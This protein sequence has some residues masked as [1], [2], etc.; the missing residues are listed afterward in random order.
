MTGETC[1]Y[2]DP[3][4]AVLNEQLLL[5][6]GG[7]G[8]FSPNTDYKKNLIS[9]NGGGLY[10]TL[11]GREDVIFNFSN[12]NLPL[13]GLS[14]ER[15]GAN[16]VGALGRSIKDATIGIGGVVSYLTVGGSQGGGGYYGG[17]GGPAGFSGAGGSGYVNTKYLK[18][19]GYQDGS[20]MKSYPSRWGYDSN[21][22]D[23]GACRISWMLN[24]ATF[25]YD[26]RYD[27]KGN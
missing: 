9:G 11:P 23:E 14:N 2:K 22:P 16:Y 6:A 26:L 21:G 4:S 18:H 27:R 7:S 3:Q 8:G 20:G 25:T 10:G 12:I 17:G 19:S 1:E 15:M 24:N 5:V 13:P